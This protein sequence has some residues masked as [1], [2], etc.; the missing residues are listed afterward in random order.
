[1]V[2][3]QTEDSDEIDSYFYELKVSFK[4]RKCSRVSGL[5]GYMPVEISMLV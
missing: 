3:Q 1:M 4:S 5:K 2:I